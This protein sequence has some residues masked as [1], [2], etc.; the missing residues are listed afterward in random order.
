MA[1]TSHFILCSVL[2]IFSLDKSWTF[3][4]VLIDLS[5]Y[6]QP[7]HV[8]DSDFFSDPS[9]CYR[10][11]E[12]GAPPKTCYYK[13]T[14][15]NYKTMGPTCRNCPNNATDCFRQYCITAD[16]YE[17][18]ITAVNQQLPGP[19]I[20]ACYGDRIIVD[21]MNSLMG[22]STTIH[23]HG[24]R[25]IGSPHMD[26]VPMITQCPILEMTTFRYDFR[27]TTSGTLYWHS[28]DGLQKQDG[29][30][31]A[32][33]IRTPTS[34]DPNSHL[35]DF[36]LASHVIFISDWMQSP[37]GNHFPGLRTH[38]TF[39]KPDSILL[40]GRGRRTTTDEFSSE[41]LY[42][43]FRVTHGKKYR[44]RLVG[45]ICTSC[46]YKFSVGHHTLLVI[47]VD[48]NPVEPV[49][50]NSID[51]YPGERYDFVLDASEHVISSWIH[52]KTI[53]NC[54]DIQ[55]YALG[56]LRYNGDMLMMPI[57]PGYA[58][59]P[60]GKVMNAYN[61][62]CDNTDQ[63]VCIVH[64][65]GLDPVPYRI[66]S[67]EPD[68]S[69]KLV[70]GF[71][72][73]SLDDLSRP[74]NYVRYF[75]PLS[76]AYLAGVVNNISFEM[77]PSPLLTQADDVLRSVLCPTGPGRTP[78]CPGSQDYCECVHVIKIPLGSVVQFLLIDNGTGSINHPF[79]MHGYSFNVIAM[80]RFKRGE[81]DTSIIRDLR[82]GALKHSNFPVYKDTIAV[83]S[84]GYTVIRIL[85]DNPGFWFFHCHVLYHAET[86][87]AVVLQ[88]G[89]DRQIPRPPAG[90]PKCGDFVPPVYSDNTQHRKTS[91]YNTG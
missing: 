89:E 14:V 68:F 85:A 46:P 7:N 62:A 55:I 77:P 67:C 5:K 66:T 28:H 30:Q 12:D 72:T 20:Q 16:G 63:G 90:F 2:F 80:G 35:Y 24:T 19:S 61:G 52:V 44:F 50:V 45:G 54:D 11:C 42:N 22:Q 41:N 3:D 10:P 64:L 36:D 48:G 91:V 32:M 58:G 17:R 56:L 13:W 86:G 76:N 73:F 79:H 83:P 82:R 31:G 71:Q 15:N 57:N 39:Q 21:V 37:A 47:A 84:M 6:L 88:V 65:V 43:V 18:G 9:S 69:F 49:R 8:M 34:L 60:S 51:I 78:G 27:A 23:W 38:D 25:Q 70:F 29:V 53:G 75:E 40:N 26:G 74:R 81:D 87:M 4:S 33:V 59:Y 1:F